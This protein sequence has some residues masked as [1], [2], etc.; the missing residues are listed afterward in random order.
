MIEKSRKRNSHGLGLSLAKEIAD[1]HHAKIL[2]ESNIEDGTTFT[3]V[4]NS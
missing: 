3:T 1:I 4:F 2:V